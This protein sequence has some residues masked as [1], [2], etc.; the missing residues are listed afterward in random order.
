VLRGSN[1]R[2]SKV[3]RIDVFTSE[4]SPLS[5]VLLIDDDLKSKDAERMAPSLGAIAAGVSLADEAMVCHF[6]LF[7]HPAETFTRDGD[8][9]LADLKNAQEA[10]EPSKMGPVPFVTPPSAHVLTN[11]EP[12]IAAPT[13]LGS[14]P[15]KALDDAVYAS[16]QLL[17][18]R[19][20][21]RRKVILL[22][23]DGI[24]GPRFNHHTH[25]E[26]LS[27]LL[28]DN[29]SVY[30]VAVDSNSFHSKFAL[31][32]SYANDS[33]GDIYYASESD[34]WRS[35]IPES[36]SRLDMNTHWRMPPRSRQKFQLPCCES[37]NDS[38]RALGRNSSRLLRFFCAG[39]LEPMMR[40]LSS[41]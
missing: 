28:R 38:R 12:P 41:R 25:A 9:L 19:D 5:L 22:I 4:A 1:Y 33:G 2:P 23:S 11:G 6:D 20:R 14:A 24:N 21:Y 34:Q 3:N 37:R 29:I 10:S 30:A 13:D 16:A 26:T 32:R 15:T 18:A 39:C 36:P 17:R 8:L 35:S 7:F 27:A 31:M 40:R